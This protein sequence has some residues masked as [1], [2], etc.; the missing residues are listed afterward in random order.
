MMHG[1]FVR[2][3]CLGL[4]N[5]KPAFERV[6][7][8]QKRF[9]PKTGFEPAHRLRHYHLKV[10]CLPISPPGQAR[11][12]RGKILFVQLYSKS[13]TLSG[14]T[15]F[16]K[17]KTFMILVNDP[18]A[19]CKSQPPTALLCCKAGVKNFCNIIF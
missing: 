4:I 2:L 6:S 5:Q 15:M 17:N 11:K 7:E 19:E 9:V 14:L 8:K 16:Y 3:D 10:A 12:N 18:L 1:F 13:C